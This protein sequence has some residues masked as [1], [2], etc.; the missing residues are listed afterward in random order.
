MY[1]WM[2]LYVS[3]CVIIWCDGKEKVLGVLILE[4]KVRAFVTVCRAAHTYLSVMECPQ[5]S[6]KQWFGR[7][8]ASLRSREQIKVGK[9]EC[10][11]RLWFKDRSLFRSMCA[12][13]GSFCSLTIG[14]ISG[15]ILPSDGISQSLPANWKVEGLLMVKI[16]SLQMTW[17]WPCSTPY[18]AAQSR[19]EELTNQEGIGVEEV[20]W[21]K[22]QRRG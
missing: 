14:T 21:G 6:L 19:E 7:V 13:V 15:C 22:A 11:S 16:E 4:V 18:L 17:L 12:H 9:A 8:S 10:D 2:C 1:L 5:L 20:R 3:V